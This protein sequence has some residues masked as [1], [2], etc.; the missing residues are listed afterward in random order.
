VDKDEVRERMTE[1]VERVCEYFKQYP[2]EIELEDNN[3]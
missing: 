3:E 2:N 1:L